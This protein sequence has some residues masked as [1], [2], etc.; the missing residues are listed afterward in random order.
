MEQP[1]PEDQER[2]YLGEDELSNMLSVNYTDPALWGR[3]SEDKI[4]DIMK[5]ISNVEVDIQ[6]LDFSA[7]KVVYK[8]QSKYATKM[9][10]YRRL[11]NGKQQKRNW[12]LYS[13]TSGKVYCIPCKLF[14]SANNPFSAGFNDWKH[15]EKISDRISNFEM[16]IQP[17]I[18]KTP[19]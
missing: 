6:E 13:N 1:Q 8:S 12:L 2:E 16:K 10:F 3:L 9:I 19:V 5:N 11:Q 17:F 14:G 15:S 7:S 4:I 18:K